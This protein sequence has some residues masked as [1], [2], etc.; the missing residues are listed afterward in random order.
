MAKSERGLFELYRTDPER[1]DALAF[2]RRSETAEHEAGRRGF[3]KGAGRA[4]TFDTCNACHS[5]MLVAQQ[6]LARDIWDETLDYMVGEQG[7]DALAPEDR[8]EIL[9][10]LSTNLS[11]DTPR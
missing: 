3:L 8:T 6:R 9:D 11:A 4:V 10:Y 2:G 1:A 7:M 5:T